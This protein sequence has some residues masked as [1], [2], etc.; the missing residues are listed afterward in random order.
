MGWG[1]SCAFA[2]G[3]QARRDQDSPP[4]LPRPRV[5]TAGLRA[6]KCHS[7][8]GVLTPS[9]TEVLR[10]DVDRQEQKQ[11]YHFAGMMAEG[12]SCRGGGVVEIVG[13]C[14][15]IYFGNVNLWQ[16]PL[17][18]LPCPFFTSSWAYGYPARNHI[19]KFPLQPSAY[20]HG[21]GLPSGCEVQVLCASSQPSS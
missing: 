4:L 13:N 8:S 15:G 20:P 10:T 14:R 6:E 11:K 12:L 7:S 16:T 21:E 5:V 18:V 17:V 2:W 9:G 1:R 19:S 3:D